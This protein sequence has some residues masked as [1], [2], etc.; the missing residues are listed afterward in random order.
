MTQESLE[1]ESGGYKAEAEKSAHRLVE[2]KSVYAPKRASTDQKRQDKKIV[3]ASETK[4][5]DEKKAAIEPEVIE[6]WE[7]D[8]DDE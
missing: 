3:E 8:Y 1:E 5:A 6:N 4:P 7:V 2:M